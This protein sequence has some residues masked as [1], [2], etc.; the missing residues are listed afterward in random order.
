[1]YLSKDREQ[2]PKSSKKMI[3]AAAAGL[4]VVGV[5]TV[6]YMNQEDT[7]DFTELASNAK[8]NKLANGFFT[9]L[10]DPCSNWYNNASKSFLKAQDDFVPQA[11]FMW[12]NK[13]MLTKYGQKAYHTSMGDMIDQIDSLVD[14]QLKVDEYWSY[15]NPKL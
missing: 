8:A 10:A 11:K 3:I 6:S 1:M 5:A 9:K 14:A 4:A 2:A 15:A 7:M 12:E 13:L